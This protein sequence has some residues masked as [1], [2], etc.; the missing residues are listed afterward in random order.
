MS[1]NLQGPREQ[2]M[3][4]NAQSMRNNGGGGNLG[5]FKGR[6]NKN[7]KD[8]DKNKSLF[9]K[10]E[11]DSFVLSNS[12]EVEEEFDSVDVF[13]KIKLFFKNLFKKFN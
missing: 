7:D 3:I 9:S 2:P 4:Q 8:K 10:D 12:E 6:K 5:Y 1:F 11:E 13:E